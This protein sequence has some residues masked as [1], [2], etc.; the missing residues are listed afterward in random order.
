MDVRGRGRDRSGCRDRG[1]RGL[2]RRPRRQA[3]RRCPRGRK[4][5]VGLRSDRRDQGF[6][7]GPQGCR[8]RRR[9]FGR[10]PRSRCRHR[11]S[12][13]DVRGGERNRLLGQLPRRQDSVRLQRSV[14]LLPE[15]RRFARMEDRNRRLRLRHALDRRRDG[16]LRGLRRLFA[17]DRHRQRRGKTADPAERLHRSE[18]GDP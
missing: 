9:R 4:P 3:L 12:A 15:N 18:S 1:R 11:Q 7:V 8:V 6:A 17:G 14:S 5:D 10:V 13:L 16:L 2:R